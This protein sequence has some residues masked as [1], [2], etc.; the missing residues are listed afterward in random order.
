MYAI[1]NYFSFVLSIRGILKLKGLVFKFLFDLITQFYLLNLL[2]KKV[3]I[4]S[5]FISSYLKNVSI[6]NWPQK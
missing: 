2:I 5:I 3:F 4:I 1:K 6:S